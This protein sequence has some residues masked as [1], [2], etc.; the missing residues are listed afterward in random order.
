MKKTITGLAWQFLPPCLHTWPAREPVE[1]STVTVFGFGLGVV[2]RW[3]GFECPV[4]GCGF[5]GGHVF[6]E[7]VPMDV[8][9]AGAGH[10]FVGHVVDGHGVLVVCRVLVALVGDF[11]QSQGHRRQR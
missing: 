10:Q 9:R 7:G 6:A 1:A 8:M 11:D 4:V 3:E 2:L 5:D